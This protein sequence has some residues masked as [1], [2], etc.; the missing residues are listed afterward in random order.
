MAGR[1]RGGNCAQQTHAANNDYKW[2]GV[3][4]GLLTPFRERKLSMHR[5]LIIGCS[6][7]GKSTLARQLA[8][9]LNLPLTHLDRLFW[10]EGW[11]MRERAEFNTLLQAALAGERWI[12]DGIYASS[13]AQ[14]LKYCDT[15]V[16]LDYPRRV[17]LFAALGRILS[18][19][20]KTRSDMA[21]GCPEHLDW[22]FLQYIWRFKRDIRPAVCRLLDEQPNIDIH[23]FRRRRDLAQWLNALPQ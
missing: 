7:S 6:G 15:V 5:I 1:V 2:H 18:G 11:Q 9:R 20:G 8:N 22:E 10:M 12:I 4:G 3:G 17:C 23:I 13:L 19:Y 14:R 16:F 21:D